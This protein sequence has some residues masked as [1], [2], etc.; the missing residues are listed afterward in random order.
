MLE[1]WQRGQGAW[2]MGVREGGEERKE[3][4]REKERKTGKKIREGINI[5]N[6]NTVV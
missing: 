3:G 4:K 2:G 5:N 1:E 6:T